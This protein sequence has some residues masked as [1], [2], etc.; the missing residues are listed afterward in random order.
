[1]RAVNFE[2]LFFV[3]ERLVCAVDDLMSNPRSAVVVFCNRAKPF[4]LVGARGQDE[5]GSRVVVCHFAI[6]LGPRDVFEGV[7]IL[8]VGDDSLDVAGPP[9]MREY[10]T[11]PVMPARA[12]VAKSFEGIA[13]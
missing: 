13:H 3:V 10:S 11:A 2:V 9:F 8:C 6:E 5:L 1:M 12:F 4:L 7:V